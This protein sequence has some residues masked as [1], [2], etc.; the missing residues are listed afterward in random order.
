MTVKSGLSSG[1]S[2]S[3]LPDYARDW[4]FF[5]DFDGT[6]LGLESEPHAVHVDPALTA[7]LD[8]LLAAANGAVAIVSGRALGDLDRLFAPVRLL[9]AGQHGVER[10]D[11]LGQVHRPPVH[12]RSLRTVARQ[13]GAFVQHHPGTFLEDK[14]TSLALHFRGAPKF[15]DSAREAI[16]GALRV[17]GD[18]YEMQL[19][20]MVFEVKARGYNK[21]SAISAYMR[22]S[23]FY[24]KVPVFIGDDLTDEHGFEIVNGLGGHTLK[25]GTGE[26][27]AKAR[28]A[29]ATAVRKWL[30]GWINFHSKPFGQSTT[31]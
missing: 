28:L 15:G 29:D 31:G 14:E 8:S 11:V 24:G 23:P 27:V 10:R 21:G 22:E 16:I 17:L 20:K 26:S 2:E 6:L 4:C 3:R 19:G 5:L 9:A 25:V 13:L 7:L 18:S 1:Q 12:A 30:A